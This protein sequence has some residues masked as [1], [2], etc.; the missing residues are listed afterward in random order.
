MRGDRQGA[1]VK[2]LNR[3]GIANQTGPQSCVP[4]REVRDEALTREPAGQPL[5]R[6][7]TP[8]IRVPTL[9]LYADGNADWRDS[10]SAC[11]AL[12]GLRP[13]HVGTLFAHREISCLAAQ[14]VTERFT[15]EDEE[16]KSMKN[17]REKSDPCKVGSGRRTNRKSQR[18]VSGLAGESVEPRDGRGEHGRATHVP[19]P[20]PGKRVQ[21]LERIREPAKQQV[22]AAADDHY[23]GIRAAR[24]AFSVR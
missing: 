13:W 19:D 2:V 6:E 4:H 20:E 21:G 14:V 17:E 22:A 10:A 9:S 24:G 23:S 7:N 5:S 18:S 3:K 16:S 1:K 15:W 11:S 12:R 8:K